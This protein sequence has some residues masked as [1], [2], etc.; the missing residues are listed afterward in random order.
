MNT[1]HAAVWIDHKEAKIFFVDARTSETLHPHRHVRR[2]QN[3]DERSHPA[4]A[5]HYFHEV[6][7]ELAGS[8]EILVVGPSSAKLELVK[9]AHKHDP[10]LAEKIVG[11]ETV[12]HP[13]DG[14]ILAYARQYFHAK[15]RMLGTA[16]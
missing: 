1:R 5:A 14:Q 3:Q 7:V 11:V 8:E 4:D 15:D 9:H 12:D 2:H 16:P 6:A 10:A 13:T